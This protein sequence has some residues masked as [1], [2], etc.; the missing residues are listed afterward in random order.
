VATDDEYRNTARRAFL[1]LRADLGLALDGPGPSRDAARRVAAEMRELCDRA[2]RALGRDGAAEFLA[3]L[4]RAQ[5]RVVGV[6]GP[7]VWE[8][9]GPSEPTP[10]PVRRRA[11]SNADV[12][13]LILAEVRALGGELT[14]LRDAAHACEIKHRVSILAS[15]AAVHLS[16]EDLGVVTR[17]MG[18]ARDHVIRVLGAS[19]WDEPEAVE[20][21]EAGPGASPSSARA[22]D[23]LPLT[24][25]ELVDVEQCA[26]IERPLRPDVV[27]RLVAEVRRLRARTDSSR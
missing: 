27:L 23:L 14:R 18:E 12:R 7:S 16:A 3:E 10:E 25:A 4:E 24:D 1:V 2:V 5:K 26:W 15:D 22:D 8:D 19:A 9:V 6:F 13:A 20:P 11:P 21:A 17:F